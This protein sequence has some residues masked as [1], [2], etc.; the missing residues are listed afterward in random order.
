[1]IQQ[2]NEISVA[3][4][5]LV[6]GASLAGVAS[7]GLF[8]AGKARAASDAAEIDRDATRALRQLTGEDRRGAAIAP[9]AVGTLIFPRVVK[10]GFVLGAQGGKGALRVGGRTRGYYSIVAAS[11]GFEAGVEAFSLAIFFMSQAALHYLDQSDGWALGTDPNVVVIDRG[12]AASVD[13]T[14]L[15]KSVVAFP[16]DQKGLMGGISIQG[17]KITT[18]NPNA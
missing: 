1:M 4:R 8:G 9:K 5:S 18:Y 16:F 11:F 2:A 10:A 14:T 12:V 7:F 13:T 15:A 3:R 17:S 6:I